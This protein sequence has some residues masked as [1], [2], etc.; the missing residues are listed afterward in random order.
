MWSSVLS[1]N[2]AYIFY[3]LNDLNVLQ[4]IYYTLSSVHLFR[5]GLMN[6]ILIIVSL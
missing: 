2:V 4:I 1:Y 5:L 6:I 3:Y